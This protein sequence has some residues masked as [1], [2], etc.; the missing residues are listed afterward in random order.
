[1]IVPARSELDEKPRADSRGPEHEHRPQS[2]DQNPFVGHEQR[3]GGEDH[4]GEHAIPDQAHA[5]VQIQV[6]VAPREHVEDDV[7]EERGDGDPPEDDPEVELTREELEE[8]EGHEEEEGP[9]E[10][11]VLVE[12]RVHA[13]GVEDG[14]GL[15]PDL[16][17][18]DAE[19]L[20]ERGLVLEGGG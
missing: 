12:V 8:A 19:L 7:E 10:I 15:A 16:A 14:G 3:H 6:P 9:R 20:E 5:S 13:D 1:M 18:V 11:G 17:R 4:H 2:E